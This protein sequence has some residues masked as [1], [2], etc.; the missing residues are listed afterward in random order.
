MYFCTIFHWKAGSD[1]CPASDAV[2]FTCPTE[3]I[4][5]LIM[6]AC[7]AH[8]SLL[9]NNN[10]AELKEGIPY[11]GETNGQH[12]RHIHSPIQSKKEKWFF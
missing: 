2:Q 4:I 5:A 6:L 10:A 3:P 1:R 11:H 12:Q 7:R 9:A 8:T